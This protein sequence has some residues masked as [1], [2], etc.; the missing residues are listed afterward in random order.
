M[1]RYRNCESTN[2]GDNL[3]ITTYDYNNL[4]DSEYCPNSPM[5]KW[6]DENASE[7]DPPVQTDH[8]QQLTME[9]NNSFELIEKPGNIVTEAYVPYA[10]R[11]KKMDMKKLKATIWDQINE[12]I[13][14]F[15]TRWPVYNIIFITF[16]LGSN[17]RR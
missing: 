10:Q 12:K 2:A 4:N 16:I 8:E 15:I 11:V 1:Y 14:S 3:N 6:E 17:R 9:E 7:S 13:V 5:N